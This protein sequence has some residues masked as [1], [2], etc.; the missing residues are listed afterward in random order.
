MKSWRTPVF[1]LILALGAAQPV[2]AQIEKQAETY[3]LTLEGCLA[4]TFR[5]SPGI[6]AARTDVERALGANLVNRS[7]A[8]PQLAAQFDGGLRGGSLYNS[9]KITTS[10]SNVISTNNAAVLYPQLYSLLTAQFSQ[11]LLDLGIQ[12]TLRRG[13]LEVVLAQQNLNR[14]VT[15]RL[16]E[17]RAIFLYALFVRDLIALR[18]DIAQRL[19]ANVENE[20]RRLDNGMGSEAALASAKIQELNLARELTDL[21]GEYFN[22]V[23]RIAELCGRD[24]TQRTAGLQT[25]RLPKP[26]GPLPYEPVQPDWTEESTYAFQHRA[27]LKLLKTLVEAMAADKQVVE[28]GYFPTVSLVASGLFIPSNLLVH[29]ET[30]IVPGQDTRSTEVRAGVALTWT[31]IDNGQVT[32]TSRLIEAVRQSYEITLHKLEQN[33]PRE[34]AVIRG[35]LQN[36]DTRR[37]ALLVSAK[38]AE[39]NLKLTETQVALGQA[40]QLDFLK[41]QSNL[42]SVRAGVA[43][44]TYFHA[45]AR[46]RLDRAT[47]RYL[48]YH[49]EKTP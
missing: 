22:A 45:I 12:P 27:D 23:A 6:Q 46:A 14:E 35:D 19:Q 5:W 13:K 36:A 33:I 25:L 31:V 41:A 49:D 17:A 43:E 28:A 9:P 8:L 16:Y 38:E 4:E 47:G 11:P 15:D 42:L 30:A 32:G 21:R 34:L 37:G 29:K 20:Q 3:D 2:V 39:E 44:A 10:A 7:R 24:P 1:I 40:T 48:Q 18:E 26:A